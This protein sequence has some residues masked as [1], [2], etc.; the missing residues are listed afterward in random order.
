[1]LKLVKSHKIGVIRSF[2][3]CVS[4]TSTHRQ[5]TEVTQFK[6]K[7]DAI[8]I[9]EKKPAKEPLVKNFFVAKVDPEL[10]AYPEAFFD[11]SVLNHATTRRVSYENYLKEE[12]FSN[13]GDGKNIHKL[14][15]VGTFNCDAMLTT[16]QF[17][18]HSEPESSNLTYNYFLTMHRIVGET[19]LNKASDEAISKFLPRMSRGE[20]IGTICLSERT[21]STIEN[22][23]FNTCARETD[24]DTWILNGEKSHVL[25]N[26]LGST[27]F[28]V[29]ASIESTD[30]EGD[31]QEKPALF[32]VDGN[33][34]GL[35][36][37]HTYTTVGLNDKIVK[38]VSLKFNNVEIPKGE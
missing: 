31:F 27:L 28:L 30:R 33:T 21:P 8:K 12:I 3:R 35:S 4:L 25:I 9:P 22:R 11:S 38:A 14:S 15:N 7:Y 1:M 23:P 6:E 17:Y 10:M 19:I 36:I 16:E 20:L 18:A 5:A 24:N 37:D 13:P 26:D 29:V 32:L 2:Y 34:P